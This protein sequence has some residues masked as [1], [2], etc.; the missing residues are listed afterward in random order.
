MR[1]IMVIVSYDGTNYH[2]FQEQRGT[3]FQTIQGILESRL[4]KM[5]GREI[6]IIGAGR[7][8]AGVHAL[9]QV[10]NFDPE[11]WPVP[12]E[13][14][15]YAL[16]SY[17]PRDIAA[18]R[19]IEVSPAFH[20]R[21]SAT[22]KR[23]RYTIYNGRVHSPLLR[24]YSCHLPQPLDAEAMAEG[25]AKLI[26]R[27]DF[28]AFR[29][30]GTPVKTTVRNLWEASVRREGEMITID[31]RADGFLYHMARMIAGTLIRVG[32]GKLLPHDVSAILSGHNSLPGG[33]TAPARGLSLEQVE[34]GE[35]SKN[36]TV[37]PMD[38]L[39]TGK[40]LY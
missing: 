32:Q 3:K 23:Y 30:L 9:G 33:P 37:N 36:K 39:D 34:N 40:A 19:S 20:A 27:H 26:G 14:V 6:R 4:A 12:T 15:A 13:K 24:L 17:L 1:N 21:F 11:D 29:A 18:I 25:A 35:N 31:L 22:A 16:N 5:T 38:N 7:T 10:I 28:A 8:D 2:G